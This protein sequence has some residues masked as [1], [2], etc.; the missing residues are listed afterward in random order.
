MKKFRVLHRQFVVEGDKIVKDSILKSRA[1]PDILI[2]NSTWLKENKSFTE[3]SVPEILEAGNEDLA[4][5]TSL[6][7]PP[8]VM[9]VFGMPDPETGCERAETSLSI[10]LDTIQDPGNLGTIIRIADWFG[11]KSIYCSTGCADIYNP[12]TVQAS[13]GAL[14]NVQVC[15]TDLKALLE[16]CRQ[17]P[18]FPVLGTFMQGTSVHEAGKVRRGMI[19]FGNESRGISADLFPFINSRITIPAASNNPAHVESLNV[20]SSVA[21]VCALITE[22][23]KKSAGSQV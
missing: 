9:A 16:Q 11:I 17:T 18:D 6:E 14:F 8:P 19:L 7:T 2:A 23:S 5:I 20:A 15:Y 10:A 4:R 1:I 21:V 22:P 12:K 3:I 13:M